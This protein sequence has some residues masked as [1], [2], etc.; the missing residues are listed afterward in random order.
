[1]LLSFWFEKDWNGNVD[2][3][4]AHA[5]LTGTKGGVQGGFTDVKTGPDGYLYI[6]DYSGT[7]HHTHTRFFFVIRGR[8]LF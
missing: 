1:M 6:A 7:S 8:P 3:S 2:W 4:H 5:L